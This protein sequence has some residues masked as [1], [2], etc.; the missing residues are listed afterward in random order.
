MAGGRIIKVL[1]KQPADDLHDNDTIRDV[2][3]TGFARA[4]TE[5][6]YARAMLLCAVEHCKNGKGGVDVTEDVG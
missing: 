6:R 3:K 4:A 5:D 2:S 1:E